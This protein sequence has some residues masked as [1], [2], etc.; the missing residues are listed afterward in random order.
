MYVVIQNF[1]PILHTQFLQSILIFV[2][3]L[4]LSY[5]NQYYRFVS[6]INYLRNINNFFVVFDKCL[7]DGR[8]R[9][10]H[11]ICRHQIDTFLFSETNFGNSTDVVLIKFVSFYV[12]IFFILTC[13]KFVY[14][15]RL[16][17]YYVR[18]KSSV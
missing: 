11:I 13:N 14:Q 1:L 5:D 9:A 6:F 8:K 12:T 18:V 3:N 17:V 4:L 10:I 15:L 2:Y 7:M 16:D